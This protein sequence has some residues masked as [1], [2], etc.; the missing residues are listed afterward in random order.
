MF[1]NRGRSPGPYRAGVGPALGAGLLVALA[2]LPGCSVRRLAVGGLADALAEGGAVYASDDDPE[3]IRDAMP[4]ALKTVETLLAQEPK[5][6]GLLVNACSS[7]AQYAYA[8][9]ETD[10]EIVEADDY[11]R[12]RALRL[13]ALG[14]YLR[15][16]DYGLRAL[17]L[18]HPGIGA[19]LPLEPVAAAA[20][21]GEAD[22]DALFWT[23]AAWGGAISLG[24]DRPDLVADL[25]VVRAL[26][27]RCL[28][29]D[30][31]FGRGAVHQ[32]MIS[33]EALPAAMGGSP[34]RARA[35]FDRAVELAD[36]L[37]SGPYVTFAAAVAVRAQ[38]HAEFVRLLEDAL[39][40]DPSADP[41]Y[42]LANRIAQIRARNLLDR[43]EELFVVV[44]DTEET[45]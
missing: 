26:L 30:E 10:A 20:G 45:P 39:A 27:R 8:F 5:H 12:A 22:V 2:L 4:F 43:A 3:L 34:E 1:R 40:I 44:E 33:I 15:A 38:D 24:L 6:R 16:R 18:S 42:R 17:E 29:L 32:A 35:H 21:I 25:D 23:A 14:L 37:Q 19:R 41:E 9:V 7:F 13:R 36:G 31:S 11:F 28:E